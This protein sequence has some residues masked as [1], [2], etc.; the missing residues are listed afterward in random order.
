[1]LQRYVRGMLIL[2]LLFLPTLAWAAPSPP[3]FVELS[4]QV[5]PAVVN[6]S[7]SKTIKQQ[8]PEDMFRHFG[9]PPRDLF[10][11]FFE[12][13]FKGHPQLKRKQRSLGSGFIISND[14]YILTNHHVV[15]EADEITVQ[16]ADDRTYEAQIKGRD[17]KLDLALL[18]IDPQENLPVAQL[19]DSNGIKV[20]EWVMAIGNPFGLE[21]TVTAGIVSATGRVIGA[22]P[23]D[24]FIQT[25][26]SINPGNSGGPLFNAQGKVIGIN[27]AIVAQGQ[28][29]GFAIPINSAK[30][31]LPQLKK[32]GHVVRGWLGVTVQKMTP[33]LAQSFGLD[34]PHG[35]LVTAVKEG[36]P[37]A[38][39]GLKRGDVIRNFDGKAIEDINDLSRTVAATKV[40]KT[41]TVDILRNGKAR[42]LKVDI[43]RMPEEL[44]GSGGQEPTELTSLGLKIGPVTAEAAERLG[45]QQQQ[46][47]L[48]MEV[49]PAS[50]ASQAQLRPGDVVRECNGREIDNPQQ[51]RRI[52]ADAAPQRPLRLL[53]QR[54]SGYLYV[55]LSPQ[56]G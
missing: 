41:A 54:G 8:S 23:Y 52:V 5:K 32:T 24:N 30:E 25:D 38:K 20:G 31:I 43:G 34:K 21:Q 47:A 9:G 6:I 17:T 12:H 48:I 16:L 37:A 22:G 39:A 14:G 1:M 55:V 53:V 49:A 42:S 40:G 10:D 44:G 3:N 13:F 4:Q 33:E 50:P 51:L 2:A 35:A 46:G 7:T 36:S 45:L 26:A 11:E 29:I 15:K 28:G 19:G 56:K 18:K 27:T